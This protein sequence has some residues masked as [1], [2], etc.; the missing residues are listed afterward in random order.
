VFAGAL[1]VREVFA[2]VRADGQAGGR[3]SVLSL[4]QPWSEKWPETENP[5]LV[6][7]PLKLWVV[8]LGHLGQGYL[9]NLGFLPASGDLL[10]LQDYQQ[11]GHENVATGLLTTVADV[12][13]SNPH[14]TRIAAAWMQQ[15]GWNTALIE[16][17]FSED[18]RAQSDD[19]AIVLS[20][21]D[22]SKP[23]QLIA[24]A[25]FPYMVDAGVGHGAVDFEMTQIRVLASGDA[26]TWNSDQR[27]RSVDQLIKR[28]AY[29]EHA[30]RHGDCGTFALAS[31]GVAVPFVGAAVGA[32][33]IA[34]SIR[35][36]TMLDTPNL[37]QLELG[38]PEMATHGRLNRPP[39]VNLGG[40]ALNFESSSE[41][42]MIP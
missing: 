39:G 5:M 29:Q 28:K 8:G 37:L 14:K 36:S 34:Q 42:S 13:G 32:L 2:T 3:E 17:K 23:R 9:W 21:L 22:D 12:T 20:A 30:K 7:L 26:T 16:R 41:A 1:A 18:T 19:P 38:C 33:V 35:L 6:Y 40:V 27:A 15:L 11:A 4:W 31:A 25:C 10:V 24:K